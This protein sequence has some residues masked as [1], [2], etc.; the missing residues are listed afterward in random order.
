MHPPHESA[1]PFPS[2]YPKET[3]PEALGNRPRY[4]PLHG[5]IGENRKQAGPSTASGVGW[6]LNTSLMWKVVQGKGIET[7]KLENHNFRVIPLCGS[8]CQ[9][10]RAP[11]SEGWMNGLRKPQSLHGSGSHSQ[12]AMHPD[13]IRPLCQILTNR[14]QPWLCAGTWCPG[15]P[16]FSSRWSLEGNPH[17]YCWIAPRSNGHQDWESLGWDSGICILPSYP[18]GAG[19]CCCERATPWQAK[20]P[21]SIIQPLCEAGSTAGPWY[22]CGSAHHRQKIG[23]SNR[24]R[25]GS[26]QRLGWL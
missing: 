12:H 3:H 10:M 5:L 8:M 23:G 13:K 16:G 9:L 26:L 24:H 21:T 6:W 17:Q 15:R 1:V 14:S 25:G 22:P 18:V 19:R 20:S 2:S 7:S 4:P 11:K